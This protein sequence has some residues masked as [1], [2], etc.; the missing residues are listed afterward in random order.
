MDKILAYEMNPPSDVDFYNNILSAAYFEDKD[1]DDGSR[2]GVEEAGYPYVYIA[3]TLRL[4]LE[5]KLGYKAAANYSAYWREQPEWGTRPREFSD[6]TFT[7]YYG[8]LEDYDSWIPSWNSE[9]ETANITLSINDGK[10]LVYLADH[11]GSQNMEYPDNTHDEGE[12][13]IYP[14]FDVT[15]LSDL[16]NLEELPLVIS[17]ACSTGWFDG[18]TDHFVT[19]NYDCF[20]E[21]II[22][23]AGGGAIA[24]IGASRHTYNLASGDLLDG[25]IH[26]F[27]PNPG[28]LNFQNAP[29]YNMGG[30][31]L[32]GKM[33]VASIRGYTD[34]D[35]ERTKT[36]FQIYH[37]FGDPETELWTE[38]PSDLVVSYPT[39]VN[40]QPNQ[41]FVVSVNDSAD[42]PIYYAKVCIQ[43]SPG[44]YEVG[45][46]NSLGQVVFDVSP[47]AIPI[48]N[49][50]VTKHD[51]IPHV[52]TIS[53]FDSVAGLNLN[54]Y[55]EQAGQPVDLTLVGFE[56]TEN[57]RLFF[58]PDE[59]ASVARGDL[60]TVTRNI[61]SGLEGYVNVMAID[62]DEVALFLL[63]RYVNVPGPDPYIYS[64]WDSS[65]WHLNPLGEFVTYNNPSIKIYQD[66][67]GVETFVDSGDLVQG[68]AYEVHVN[69]SN[70]Q[71]VVAL[72][73][74]VTVTWAPF[75]GGGDWVNVD[76]TDNP[77]IIPLIGAEDW[78]IAKVPW[79]PTMTGHKCIKASV[80]HINDENE[81]NNEGQE[82]TDIAPA[83]SPG[84]STFRVG[85]PPDA[86]ADAYVFLKVRQQGG[87]SDYWEATIEDYSSQRLAPGTHENVT[88]FV[89][90]PDNVTVGSW[91][92]FII[93]LYIDGEF[94]DGLSVN[95]TKEEPPSTLPLL[96][97]LEQALAIIG[98]AIVAVI[99]IVYLYKKKK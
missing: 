6:Q 23:M 26:A 53:V 86:G 63:K 48:M 79:T 14:W 15:D 8:H 44:V 4:Y 33:N 1:P 93:N 5:D 17:M 43:Q 64:Q 46:T 88:L 41:R 95:V 97:G 90:I 54:T 20:S 84:E 56:G 94:V 51:F 16:T 13:W 71:T 32:F 67:G 85:N 62:D 10:F 31:L 27:W 89:V 50:T 78:S 82:N 3:E 60:P 18:E 24:A 36:T 72:N 73:V 87:F 58:G 34:N 11:G 55:R 99:V 81:N 19:R 98:G 38:S 68:T 37:L 35:K 12:G 7:G 76:P 42:N 59:V 25:I 96:I 21:E 22:R 66:I 49:I 69:V 47:S 70:R 40:T 75:G 83:K 2:N 91:R 61:P 9:F 28:F 45:Y 57:I 74:E 39:H 29:I 92:L 52:E 77:T 65:T 30:A 80:Y